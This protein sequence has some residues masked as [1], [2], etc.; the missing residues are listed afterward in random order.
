MN[1]HPGRHT[2]PSLNKS[3][4][5]S[6]SNLVRLRMDM[7]TLERRHLSME[8]IQHTRLVSLDIHHLIL[9][10]CRLSMAQSLPRSMRFQFRRDNGLPNSK[11]SIDSSLCMVDLRRMGHINLK[12]H[13]QEEQLK[14]RSRCNNSAASWAYKKSTEKAVYLRYLKQ[15]KGRKANWVDLLTNLASKVNLAGCSLGSVVELVALWGFLA[16]WLLV[17]KECHFQTLGR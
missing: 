17:L 16:Q 3:E 11:N 9:L 14:S 15:F 13:Q 7:G 2:N 8:I 12:S 5:E 1:R 10:L 6:E 4:S